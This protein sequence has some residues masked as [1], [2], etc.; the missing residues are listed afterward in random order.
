[1]Y[2]C[3]DNRIA[4]KL[5]FE[6]ESYDALINE[7]EY[8]LCGALRHWKKNTK[9]TVILKREFAPRSKY[10]DKEKHKVLLIKS[11]LVGNPFI[12]T[13]ISCLVRECP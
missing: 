5:Y 10:T 12:N 9:I 4:I 6:Y 8:P 3:E 13:K 11:V 7:L 1:M 2:A